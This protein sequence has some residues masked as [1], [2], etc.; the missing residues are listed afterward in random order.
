METTD[1]VLPSIRKFLNIVE[2]DTVFDGEIIPHIMSA[3]GKLSQN[4][5]GNPQP[6][7]PTLTW[8]DVIEPTMISNPEVFAMVPLY[9]MLSV[10]I[11]FD[12]P[13][14]SNVSYYSQYIEENLWRL[15]QIYDISREVTEK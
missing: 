1:Y 9:V 6:I 10:K 2:D 5:I 4:G 7:T 8:A 14:P 12:P 3:F 15:K 11:L 13:P